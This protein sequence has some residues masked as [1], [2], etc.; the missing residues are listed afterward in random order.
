MYAHKLIAQNENGHLH[1]V[2]PKEI[3]TSEVEVILVP[4]EKEGEVIDRK[5]LINELWGSVKFNRTIDE[6]DN[7]IR[8]MRDE[9]DRDI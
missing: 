4:I 8:K 7:D 3:T 9:R 1:I 5:A 6:I 2:L